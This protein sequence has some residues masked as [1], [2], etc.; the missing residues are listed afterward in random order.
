MVSARRILAPPLD[1]AAL[2]EDLVKE[3]PAEFA[4]VEVEQAEQA[5]SRAFPDRDLLD[6]A[7]VTVDPTG[8][9]DLDQAVALERTPDGFRVRYAIADIAAFV[10]PGSPL[11][12]VLSTR[13]Q[14][15][16]FPDLRIG[17]HPATLSEGAASLLPG[18]IRPAVVWTIDVSANGEI[19]QTSVV[20]ALV[21]S[22]RQYDYETVQRLTETG[23]LP[24]TL[25]ALPQLGEA[26]LARH[27]ARGAIETR[28][29]TQEISRDD[30]G[31]YHLKF[32]AVLPVEQYNAQ[33]SL[34]TGVAAAQMMLR[35]G[36]GLLRTLPEPDD[37]AL[38]AVRSCANGLGVSWPKQA[39]AADVLAALKPELPRHAAVLHESAMLLRGSGYAAF[40]GTVPSNAG[41]AGVGAP[42]AHVTAPLRRLA[43]RYA[44]EVCL[45]LHAGSEVPQWVRNA[46]PTLPDAMNRSNQRANAVERAVLD[47][48]EAVVLADRLGE[49]FDAVVLDLDERGNHD[50]SD[51][52]ADIVV[53]ALAV[54]AKCEGEAMRAGTMINAQVIIAN[55]ATRQVRFSAL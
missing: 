41:H 40:D 18:Q 52:L 12:Q 17:L 55:P 3:L 49:N 32:R 47:Y 6:I 23:N 29:P 8:S 4:A 22:E 43:D 16:Y 26:L 48:T 14:T 37:A 34:L 46:L 28:L 33:I 11:D 5:A 1:Y 39:R 20:R 42:Y 24:T 30:A 21:R 27:R 9:K 19:L 25:R 38:R 2:R 54:R 7:F 15:F 45:A 50:P 53:A 10:D 35:G 36:I 44:T 31:Q 13:G 51:D